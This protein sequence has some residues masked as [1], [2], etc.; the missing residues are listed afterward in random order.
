MLSLV[1]M[2]KISIILISSVGVIFIA[3]CYM[4]IFTIIIPEKIYDDKFIL[5][6]KKI[7]SEDIEHVYINNGRSVK[8]SLRSNKKLE[9]DKIK[10]L[11]EMFNYFNDNHKELN[12]I[13]E[14]NFSYLPLSLKHYFPEYKFY[15]DRINDRRSNSWKFKKINRVKVRR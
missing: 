15:R 10:L 13:E 3:A 5:E 2:R 12:R 8:I 1:Y 11:Y 7:Y 4:F 14:I 9:K 6:F